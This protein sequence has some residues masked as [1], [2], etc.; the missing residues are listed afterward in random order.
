[1]T[2]VQ[3]RPVHRLR[4][5]GALIVAIA[6]VAIVAYLAGGTP[7]LSSPAIWGS[8]AVVIVLVAVIARSRRHLANNLLL[9]I[10]IVA[11]GSIAIMMGAWDYIPWLTSPWLW[12]GV[13]ISS[14]SAVVL[15]RSGRVRPGE[16][17]EGIILGMVVFA[18]GWVALLGA[19]LIL[20]VAWRPF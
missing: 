16:A 2:V 13:V 3:A 17:M 6:C 4:W 1:V 18:I 7:W 19:V 9:G 15:V 14:A 20:W 11:G 12:L 10:P 8:A 5:L